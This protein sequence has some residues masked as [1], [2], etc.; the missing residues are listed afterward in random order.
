ML[1]G[2]LDEAVRER[3]RARGVDGVGTAGEDDDAGLQLGDGVEGGGAGDT[4]G[5]DG[6]LPDSTGDEV[7]VLRAIVEDEDEVACA[8]GGDPVGGPRV[9]GGFHLSGSEG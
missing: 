7:R 9:D 4:Q 5:E 3:R 6:E 1:L 2:V 8:A